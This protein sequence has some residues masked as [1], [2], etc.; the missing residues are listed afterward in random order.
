VS[1]ISH[2]VTLYPGDVISTGAPGIGQLVPG[3]V[4]ESEI[5]GIGC[6]SNR[7]EASDYEGA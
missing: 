3:D 2:I 4:M 5:E 6:F 7:I 1:W